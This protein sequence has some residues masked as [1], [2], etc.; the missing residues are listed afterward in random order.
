MSSSSKHRGRSWSNLS[1]LSFEIDDND[2]SLMNDDVDNNDNSLMN[3][4]D[5]NDNNS[6]LNHD[7]NKTTMNNDSDWDDQNLNDD[8]DDDDI[9][10]DSRR[11]RK[12]ASSDSDWDDQMNDDIPTDSRRPR[13]AKKRKIKKH[14]IG[15]GNKKTGKW[16]DCEA[17]FANDL[18]FNFENGTLED[19]DDGVTLRAY[20]ALKLNCAPM[21]ISKKFAGKCI[22][23]LIFRRKHD[24][25]TICLKAT[26]GNISKNEDSLK[27]SRSKRGEL[28]KCQQQEEISD[29]ADATSNEST[30]GSSEDDDIVNHPFAS[31]PPKKSFLLSIIPKIPSISNIYSTSTLPLASATTF[32][33]KNEKNDEND[34]FDY[35]VDYLDTDSVGDIYYDSIQKPSYSESRSNSITD[36]ITVNQSRLASSTGKDRDDWLD[37]LNMFC[38]SSMENLQQFF[39]K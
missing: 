20:L 6:I 26:N 7:N 9:P 35:Y 4:N 11:S 39:L 1:N 33:M 19:C 18:I 29:S 14:E 2:T 30:H 12:A 37:T 10:I 23:K 17:N 36:D 24:H 3:D 8:D 34:N 16:S 25:R 27:G 21:R 13:K 5:N 22:G 32:I 28:K 38:S 31:Q 15:K